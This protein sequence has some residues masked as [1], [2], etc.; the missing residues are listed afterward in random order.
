MLKDGKDENHG[1][2]PYALMSEVNAS[3]KKNLPVANEVV[4][5][6]ES[7]WQFLNPWANGP[8]GY[9]RGMAPPPMPWENSGAPHKHRHGKRGNWGCH[10][11]P[12]HRGRRGGRGHHGHRRGRRGHHHHYGPP[13]PPPF[14]A[15]MMGGPPQGSCEKG[16]KRKFFVRFVKHVTLNENSSVLAGTTAT[17]IWQIRNDH[18]EAWAVSDYQLVSV[19]GDS[20][21][22]CD[23]ATQIGKSF[24]LPSGETL[25]LKIEFIAPAEPGYYQKNFRVM[26]QKTGKKMGQRLTL[27]IE[28]VTNESSGSLSSTSSSSS[29][30]DSSD[31][32]VDSDDSYYNKRRMKYLE[33]EMKSMKKQKEKL[34]K[35]MAKVE[36]KMKRISLKSQKAKKKNKD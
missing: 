35:R 27:S 21:I 25:D 4:E 36:S 24:S 13:P 23:E 30:S 32:E 34:D 5:E 2:A 12:G 6:Q 28:V 29:S 8:P 18:A 26:D 22:I 14:L 1:S 10:G 20:D 19:G 7:G 16:Y 15:W 33:K 31:S 9:G 17:K 11:P 3:E